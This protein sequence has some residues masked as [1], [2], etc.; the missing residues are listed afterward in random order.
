[1]EVIELRLK[2]ELPTIPDLLINVPCL[3]VVAVDVAIVVVV[4]REY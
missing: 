3:R 4:D 2:P 1:M